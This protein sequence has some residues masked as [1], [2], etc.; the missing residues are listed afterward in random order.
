MKAKVT[1]TKIA[2][3]AGVA[4][5]AAGLATPLAGVIVPNKKGTS[6]HAGV[7]L[8]NKNGCSGSTSSCAMLD[9]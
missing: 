5:L 2:L 9:V 4:V 8:P 7:I 6:L 1:R 3:A